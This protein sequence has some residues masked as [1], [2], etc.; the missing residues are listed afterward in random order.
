MLLTSAQRSLYEECGHSPSVWK[1]LERLTKGLDYF[2]GS[3][4]SQSVAHNCNR[5]LEGDHFGQICVNKEKMS[6]LETLIHNYKQIMC[7][8]MYVYSNLGFSIYFKSFMVLQKPDLVCQVHSAPL[9]QRLCVVWSSFVLKLQH[10][11]HFHKEKRG[12]A[13]VWPINICVETSAISCF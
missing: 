5:L 13:L 10:R 9:K 1:P 7:F 4:I 12:N 3:N 8:Y 2:P 6:H 11:A